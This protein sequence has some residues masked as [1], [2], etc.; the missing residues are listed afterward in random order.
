M[1]TTALPLTDAV[2]VLAGPGHRHDEI[3]A[4]A[5]LDFIGRLVAAFGRRRQELL[6]E[7]RRQALRL[8]AGSPLDFPMV[9]AAVRADS[10]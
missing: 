8:A 5:A 10:G 6:K 4:P 3:L 1:T 7:R 2:R 9:T